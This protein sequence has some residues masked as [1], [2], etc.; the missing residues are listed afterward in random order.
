MLE[1]YDKS[2]K[3]PYIGSTQESF[4]ITLFYIFEKTDSAIKTVKLVY[5]NKQQQR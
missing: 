2:F 3:F 1:K 4:N 5:T